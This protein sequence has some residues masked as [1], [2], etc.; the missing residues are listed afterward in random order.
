MPLFSV[1]RWPSTS[2]LAD[3]DVEHG[4]ITDIKIYG[5]FFGGGD[6][7]ELENALKDERLDE[8]LDKRIDKKIDVDYYINGMTSEDLK[9]LLR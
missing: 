8:D 5:D 7:S 4:K 2:P 3:I 6:I 1:S 9:I